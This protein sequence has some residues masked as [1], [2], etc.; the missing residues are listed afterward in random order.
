[1]L[2]SIPAETLEVIQ[3]FGRVQ[4]TTQCMEQCLQRGINVVFYS[5]HGSYFGRLVSTNHVNVARQRMQAAMPED[6]KLAV[7]KNIINAKIQN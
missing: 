5:A 3:V 6:F 4:L 1:M 2:R 7:S